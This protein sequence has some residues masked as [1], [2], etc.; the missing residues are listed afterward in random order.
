MEKERGVQGKEVMWAKGVVVVQRVQ[1][2]RCAQCVCVKSEKVA[3]VSRQW[4]GCR[5]RK[6]REKSVCRQKSKTEA[7]AGVQKGGRMCER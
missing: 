2:Q 6:C 3:G 7:M 4:E 5:R 1:C